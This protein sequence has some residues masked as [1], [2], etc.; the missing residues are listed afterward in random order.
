MRASNPVWNAK[1]FAE[2][3]PSRDTVQRMSTDGVVLKT[4]MLALLL[5]VT[6]TYSWRVAFAEE[7]PDAA[8]VLLGWG[9]FGGLVTGLIV[10]IWPRSAV[11]FAPVYALFEGLFLGSISAIFER[12]YPGIV[13]PSVILTFGVLFV[14]LGVYRTGWIQVTDTFTWG[15]TAA[16]GAIA[17][18]YLTDLA[19]WWFGYG[20]VPFVHEGG[21]LGIL[22]SLV[23]VGVAALN[24]VLDFEFVV[25]GVQR[26]APKYMEWVAAF[27][28][29]VTIIWVYV[30]ILRFLA[31]WMGEDDSDD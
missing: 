17:L 22:F 25:Q 10:M 3:A 14:M 2:I 23:V 20:G 1:T 9:I 24:L 5:L 4:G 19:L 13:I 30:E 18:I 12:A 7:N 26:G 21:V 15:V 29:M 16:T 8:I 27:G 11:F 28:L 6:T 31:K